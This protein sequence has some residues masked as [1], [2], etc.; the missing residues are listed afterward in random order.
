VRITSQETIYDPA[1]PP[2]LRKIH[3]GTR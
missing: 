1:G 3:A 2:E